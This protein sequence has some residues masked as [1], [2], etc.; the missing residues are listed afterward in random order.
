ME[1]RSHGCGRTTGMTPKGRN[2]ISVVNQTLEKPPLLLYLNKRFRVSVSEDS[3]Y[4]PFSLDRRVRHRVIELSF[5]MKTKEGG[6]G[7]AQRNGKSTLT[8]INCIIHLYPSAQVTSK[9]LIRLAD[10]LQL[11]EFYFRNSDTRW[12]L[13]KD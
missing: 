1:H 7:Q 6:R 5:K 13:K 11:R 8:P 9:T 12:A 2:Q 3:T 10:L 4:R